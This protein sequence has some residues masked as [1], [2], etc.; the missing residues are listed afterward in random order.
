[1]FEKTD[2]KFL[3]VIGSNVKKYRLKNNISQA[4]LAFEINTTLRQIQRIEAGSANFGILYLRKIA[5]VLEIETN[6]LIIE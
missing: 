6:K 3:K 4:Q 5:E 1:M 2:K